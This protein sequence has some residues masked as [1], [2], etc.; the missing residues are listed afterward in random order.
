MHC[1]VSAT[2]SEEQRRLRP[3]TTQVKLFPLTAITGGHRDEQVEDIVN[4]IVVYNAVKVERNATD[5][6]N[7]VISLLQQCTPT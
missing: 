2:F 6:L 7:I 5:I 4:E 1:R 3:P